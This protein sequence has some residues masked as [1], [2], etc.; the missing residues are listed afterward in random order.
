MKQS[1][2]A[3]LDEKLD[4]FAALATTRSAGDERGATGHVDVAAPTRP[5]NAPAMH[6]NAAAVS[7]QS[8]MCPMRRVLPAI[9]AL[10]ALLV[11]VGAAPA[12]VVCTVIVDV[13]S[14][15]TLHRQGACD[16]RRSPMSSFKFPLALMAADA[17][18][19]MSPQQPRMEYRPEF[20]GPERVRKPVDPAVWMRESIL[21]Y[22]Q[23]LTRRLG[24]YKLRAYVD[25][26]G[27]GNRDLSGNRGKNDGLTQA[28][29]MSSLEISPDEQVAFVR[30]FLTRAFP[31][32]ADA[33]DLT[34][35]LVP[36][37]PAGEGWTVHGKTG[38]G[39]LRKP[40]G[41]VDG[42]RPLGWFVG[43][44]EKGERRLAFARLVIE[45]RPSATPG[46]FLARDGF[47]AELPGLVAPR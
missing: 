23:A 42:G 9:L 4:C 1:S 6:G 28:W 44:A 14:G 43:W 19:V 25:G 16:E 2:F 17:G 45:D 22:S 13:A 8:R 41:A 18:I 27:Y 34:A 15:E 12:A 21:W 35:E 20:G 11:S 36:V 37:F 32:S 29:L 7:F 24:P 30:D 47:I 26:F 46:G 39:S 5:L 40:S 38:S 31:L 33:Y 3:A 10:A